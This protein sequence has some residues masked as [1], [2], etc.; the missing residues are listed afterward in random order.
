MERAVA[1]DIYDLIVVGGGPAGL[2]AAISGASELPRVALLDSGR[3][4]PPGKYQRQLGGQAIGSTLIENYPGFPGGLSGC[5]LMRRFEEQA[6]MLGAEIFCPQHAT[7]LSL[8]ENN[9]KRITTRSNGEFIAK[10]VIIASG[11]S[12]RKL[13]APGVKELLGKGVQYGAPTFSPEKLGTCNICVVGA[14]NSAGQ[15]VMHLS[16]N[17]NARIKVLV[18]G[19]KPIETQ[20]S[21]Y[22]VERVYGCNNVEVIQDRMV[23]GA[24]GSNDKL[25]HITL[26]DGD[27]QT[28]ELATDHLFI[29]IGAE[30]KVA[31]LPPE[32]AKDKNNFI[33]TD[34]DLGR[35]NGDLFAFETSIPGV[36]AAGDIRHGSV[37]RVAAGGGEGSA[38]VASVHRWLA[39]R[40]R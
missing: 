7:S 6:L 5:E 8:V 11:L 40:Q 18:R 37:K 24:Y 35:I 32:L 17:P 29:F 33:G 19:K 30:P 28:S 12:Y 38:A 25:E 14:A 10:T 16:Q 13:D 21:K 4:A 3:K 2:S 23:I 26:S 15:A 31:W 22:L 9:L 39:N 34:M 20:M 27:G 1:M 36:F